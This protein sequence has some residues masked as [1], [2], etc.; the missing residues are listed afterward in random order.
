MGLPTLS[1]GGGQ[2]A[3]LQR[4]G[5]LQGDGSSTQSEDE[6]AEG[7][8]GPV[9]LGSK[10]EG[11]GGGPTACDDSD[12]DSDAMSVRTASTAHAVEPAVGRG[13]WG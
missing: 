8:G 3:G 11:L 7:P 5:G 1:T 6:E 12:T 13:P 4:A 9:V 2:A 10:L